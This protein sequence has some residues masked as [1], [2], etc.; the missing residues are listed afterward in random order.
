MA[1]N[2]RL[3][4]TWPAKLGAGVMLRLIIVDFVNRKL[5]EI[6]KE[7]FDD[8]IGY[9]HGLG[10]SRVSSDFPDSLITARSSFE[11]APQ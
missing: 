3:C 4:M 11:G 8:H 5:P 1:Y 10:T 9:G 2:L 6:H 7:L